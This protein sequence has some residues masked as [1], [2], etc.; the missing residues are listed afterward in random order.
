MGDQGLTRREIQCVLLAGEGLTNKEIAKRLR[1][2][3]SGM[4]YRT[5]G[6]HLSN[7]Y[8]KLGTANREEAAALVARNYT[9]RPIPMGISVG[10]SRDHPI[11]GSYSVAAGDTQP[12]SGGLYGLYRK[13]GAW[14][15]PP[16]WGG[17]RSGLIV[18]WACIGLLLISVVLGLVT[19]F[20]SVQRAGEQIHSSTPAI[21]AAA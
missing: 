11:T 15:T 21:E 8:Q 10:S 3:G 12:V 1:P 19:V 4:S 7:A 16:R 20:G 18:I 14:R 9:D 13:L 17:S 6:N 5:V 2:S